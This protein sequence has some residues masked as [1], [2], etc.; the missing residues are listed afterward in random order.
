[1]LTFT[2]HVI[3]ALYNKQNMFP[4]IEPS[5]IRKVQA[6]SSQKQVKISGIRFHF[7]KK[8]KINEIF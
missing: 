5:V 8:E 3:S 7:S 1:M 6:Q 2:K 4:F